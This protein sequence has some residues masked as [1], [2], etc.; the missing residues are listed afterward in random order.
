MDFATAHEW[1]NSW[2]AEWGAFRDKPATRK[3]MTAFDELKGSERDR[4]ITLN[5]IMG[6]CFSAMKYKPE[7]DPGH[8]YRSEMAAQRKAVASLAKAA[9]VLAKA[10]ERDDRAMVWALP[11]GANVLGVKLTRPND[12]HETPICKMGAAFF[13]ELES[14]L[15]GKLPELNGGPFMSRFTLGNLHFEK[16]LKAGRPVEV[17][18]MLAFELAF[19]LR[20]FTEGRAGDVLQT[21]QPMPKD[22]K[23]CAQV[24]AAFCNAA[25]A[26]SLSTEQVTDRLGKLPLDVGLC[27]WPEAE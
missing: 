22:G 23:P 13:S 5:R 10:C 11:G 1:R 25:L 21:A 6:A 26:T 4:C 15:T 16:P 8:E 3:A 18:S 20:M 9:R 14:S 2:F 12:G 17:A 7:S 19:Y 24:I 27:S